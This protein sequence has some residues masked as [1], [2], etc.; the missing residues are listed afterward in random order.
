MPSQ[1]RHEASRLKTEIVARVDAG[2]TLRAVCASSGMPAGDAVRRWARTD[3]LFGEALAAAYRRG[4]WRRLWAFDE[5]KAAAFLARARAGEPVK[6]LLGQPGMPS[7]EI[8][9]RWKTAQ[10]AFAEAVF[11]LLRRRDAQ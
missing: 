1:Y 11:A 3:P 5:A 8:Y 4:T 9:R 2:D 6:S 10:P 7:R